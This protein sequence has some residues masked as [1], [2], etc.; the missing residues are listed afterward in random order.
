MCVC[1][2]VCVRARARVC[3]YIYIYIKSLPPPPRVG[4]MMVYTY[5]A[6]RSQVPQESCFRT[7]VYQLF[8]PYSEHTKLEVSN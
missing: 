8:T 3:V 5:G 4:L 2:G 1:V 7:L 6:I